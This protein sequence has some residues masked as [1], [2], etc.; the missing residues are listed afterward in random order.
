MKERKHVAEK[1]KILLFTISSKK[2]QLHLVSMSNE[3]L[4]GQVNCS[5]F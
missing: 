2:L 3:F 5:F 1:R 4:L